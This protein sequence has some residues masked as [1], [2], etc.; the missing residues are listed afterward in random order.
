MQI[1]SRG[2]K[3]CKLRTHFIGQDED[4]LVDERWISVTLSL[5][6]SAISACNRMVKK[7]TTVLFVQFKSR[8]DNI[9]VKCMGRVWTEFNNLSRYE[10]YQDY[11][12]HSMTQRALVKHPGSQ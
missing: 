4:V 1:Y 7:V 5:C 11:K 9:V 10:P 8:K 12:Y 3:S 6:P 2:E